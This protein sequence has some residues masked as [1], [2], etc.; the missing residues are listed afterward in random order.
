[1]QT[2]DNS[3]RHSF[4]LATILL[5][6]SACVPTIAKHAETRGVK[7]TTGQPYALDSWRRSVNVLK[8]HGLIEPAGRASRNETYRLTMRGWHNIALLVARTS[9]KDLV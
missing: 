8:H 5:N 9:V 2:I 6:Q 3:K 1:M 7:Q 4:V